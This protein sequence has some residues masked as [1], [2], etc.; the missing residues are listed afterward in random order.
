VALGDSYAAGV[1]TDDAYWLPSSEVCRRS[2][3]A[4]PVLLHE[5]LQQDASASLALTFVACTGAKVQDVYTNQLAAINANSKYITLSIGGNDVDF[6]GVMMACLGVKRKLP[7]FTGDCSQEV[8]NK[9]SELPA[10]RTQ[11]VKLYNDI[12]TKAPGALVIVTSYPHLVTK[13]YGQVVK[14][15]NENEVAALQEA[16]DAMDN[17]LR[18]ATAEAGVEFAD[19][20]QAFAGRGCNGNPQWINCIM[21]GELQSRGVQ[22]FHPNIEGNVAYAQVVLTKLS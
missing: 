1:G 14:V 4:W 7:P 15:I 11:L 8:L 16:V 22:S 6:Q 19:V 21:P 18:N 20:R 13:R 9:T 17:M 2:S 5:Q 3:K 12:K 10:L